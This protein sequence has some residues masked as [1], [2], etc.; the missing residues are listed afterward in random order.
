MLP[1][2][3]KLLI[4]TISEF[5]LIEAVKVQPSEYYTWL[6][7]KLVP[8]WQKMQWEVGPGNRPSRDISQ[9]HRTIA[10]YI[11]NRFAIQ[12]EYPTDF[13]VI[14]DGHLDTFLHEMYKQMVVPHDIKYNGTVWREGL[15]FMHQAVAYMPESVMRQIQEKY[16]DSKFARY[17]EN[18]RARWNGPKEDGVV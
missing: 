1:E 13:D 9:L 15:T 14:E 6:L 12:D 16:P 5:L 3:F 18:E 10:D 2:N 11:Q 8:F 7:G 17:V 4:N